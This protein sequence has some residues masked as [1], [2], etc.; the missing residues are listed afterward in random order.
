MPP[1][2]PLPTNHTQA[3]RA[4]LFPYDAQ[5]SK[6]WSAPSPFR[7]FIAMSL[8]RNGFAELHN[9]PIGISTPVFCQLSTVTFGKL[10]LGG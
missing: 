10:A 2:P 7:P 1:T 5:H 9:N 4:V 6:L 3:E 8:P